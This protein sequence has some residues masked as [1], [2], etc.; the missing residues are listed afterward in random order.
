MQRTPSLPVARWACLALAASAAACTSAPVA[1][2]SANAD[3][4][5]IPANE[6][7]ATAFVTQTIRAT[8]QKGFDEDHHA[9]RDA[10]R[11]AHGCVQARFTVRPD[12]P[13]PLAQGLFAQAGRYDA[14]VRFSNGSGKSQDD[15]DRDARGMAVKV[16]GVPG[17]KVLE[18]QR[19][20]TTQDFVM[21][22]HPVFFIHDAQDYVDFVGAM[23]G[24]SLRKAG[25]ALTH[26][27]D[28]VPLV[29]AFTGHTID[30]PLNSRYWSTTPS[31]LGSG[32]MKFS[33]KPCAASVF[34]EAADKA[35]QDRDRLGQNLR[36]QLATQSACF[37]FMVQPRTVPAHMPIEDATV[38]WSEAESPFVTVATIEVPPQTPDQG[39]ACERLS[40]SPWHTLPA[41]QPL[42]TISRMRK[43]VYQ[44]ISTLRHDLNQQPQ[45]EPAGR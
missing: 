5:V 30:N 40:F 32:Q 8:V 14:V 11:K 44:T 28:N 23:N 4:E 6:A 7:A 36:R 43:V 21:T 12:L 25:W 24:G 34:D 18:G 31:R 39:E 33:A 37:D 15:H 42:G 16:M 26:L 19:D 29:V 20:A 38:E 2:P 41:H 1:P 3:G 27:F 9:F 22:N 10:H 45:G 35:N 17:A 13:A